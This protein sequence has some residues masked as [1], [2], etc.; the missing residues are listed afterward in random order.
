M[1][2]WIKLHR[3]LQDSSIAAHPEYLAVWIHLMLRAQHSASEC[4][5][6]R[7]IVKLSVGQLVFGRIKFSA[8]IGVTE[9]KVRAA[10][11]VMK[12]LNMITIKSMAKFSIISIVKWNEYQTESPANNHETASTSPADHQQA[13]TYKN[14]KNVNNDKNKDLL[15]DEKP[16]KSK[17]VKADL[18]YSVWPQEP[19]Q[20]L[21]ADWKQVRSANK[22]PIT[23]TVLKSFGDEFRKAAAFG[24]TVDDCLRCAITT[25][26]GWTGFKFE[27]MQNQL[28]KVNSNA[29]YQSANRSSGSAGSLAHDDTKWAD[30]LFGTEPPTVD[31]FDQQGVQVLEGDFSRLGSSD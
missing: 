12:T 17:S 22:A 28:S 8:E 25:G 27:W 16:K 31:R 4:V 14:D 30:E 10:L 19:D 5:I 6:G 7:Q 23:Q 11:D 13:A 18:D 1:S 21:L 29:G 15:G 3:S 24:Y 26:K 9:N 20:Q 2:G